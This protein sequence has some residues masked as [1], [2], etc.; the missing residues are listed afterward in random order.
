MLPSVILSCE[1]CNFSYNFRWSPNPYTPPPSPLRLIPSMAKRTVPPDFI[2]SDRSQKHYKNTSHNLSWPVGN[3]TER[4]HRL[5]MAIIWRTFRRDSNFSP[6]WSRIH[7]CTFLLRFLGIILKV[8]RLEVFVYNVHITNQ[9]QTTFAQ[10]G[11]G[12]PLV[13]VTVN[14]KEEILKTFVPITS[15]K[16]ASA[17]PFHFTYLLYLLDTSYVAPSTPTPA[18][19][20]RLPVARFIVHDCRRI[21]S[22]LCRSQLY[23]PFKDYEFGYCTLFLAI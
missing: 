1:T 22:T 20:A 21:K 2:D 8:F 6:A 18:K 19:L 7:E 4:V 23:P 11:G 14:T 9:F 12:D 17:L 5:A 16:S 15:K 3:I 13:E 10:R